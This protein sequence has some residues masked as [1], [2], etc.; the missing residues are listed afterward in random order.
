[1]TRIALMDTS[2]P[3]VAGL[4]QPGIESSR[5]PGSDAVKM[6][7]EFY[8]CMQLA[9]EAYGGANELAEAMGAA[10]SDT[11]LRVQR[12]EDS[13]GSLQRAFVDFFGPLLINAKAKRAFVDALMEMLDYE[14]PVP[15]RQVTDEDIGRGAV[16]WLRSLPLS[17][18]DAAKADIARGLGIRVED[19]KL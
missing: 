9:V 10:R 13:K 2:V 5:N 3:T 16:E 18:R 1:M 8:R 14:P 6:R 15:R 17:M 4:T 11:F 19:L 12:K 7:D